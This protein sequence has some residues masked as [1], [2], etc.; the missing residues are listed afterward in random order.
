MV[1]DKYTIHVED[2]FFDNP[3]N[4][5]NDFGGLVGSNAFGKPPDL[6]E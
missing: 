2:T 5:G 4:S 1:K 6:K 3:P